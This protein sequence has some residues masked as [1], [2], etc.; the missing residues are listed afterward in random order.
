MDRPLP[1]RPDE[2][3]ISLEI[4]N[5]KKQSSGRMSMEHICDTTQMQHLDKSIADPKPSVL[6]SFPNTPD[7]E[8]PLVSQFRQT[9][10][11]LQDQVDRLSH[12]RPD[13]V[14]DLVSWADVTF[15]K[16]QYT[17]SLSLVQYEDLSLIHI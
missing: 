9:V 12:E 5:E 16:I 1:E 15:R 14:D 6:T 17:R 2:G 13:K 7:D 4:I 10:L 3:I 8:P 11:A